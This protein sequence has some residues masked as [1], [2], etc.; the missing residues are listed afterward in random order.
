LY[1][2]RLLDTFNVPGSNSFGSIDEPSDAFLIY[3]NTETD[4]IFYLNMTKLVGRIL[5]VPMNF[6]TLKHKIK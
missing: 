3:L 2:H 5:S 4:L 6:V 1:N